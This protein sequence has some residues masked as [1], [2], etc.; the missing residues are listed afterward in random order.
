L[1]LLQLLAREYVLHLGFGDQKTW[2]NNLA[3]TL[4]IF[5]NTMWSKL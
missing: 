5:L 4:L 2:K 3:C 1:L